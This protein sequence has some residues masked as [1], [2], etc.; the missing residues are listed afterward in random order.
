MYEKMYNDNIKKINDM[1][2]EFNEILND[3]EIDDFKAAISSYN[4]EINSKTDVFQLGIILLEDL[5]IVRSNQIPHISLIEKL[6]VYIL[7]NMLN[8]YS[9]ERKTISEAYN[10]FVNICINYDVNDKALIYSVK[11]SNYIPTADYPLPPGYFNKYS[12]N[13]NTVVDNTTP[14]NRTNTDYTGMPVINE[15]IIKKLKHPQESPIIEQRKLKRTKTMG[16]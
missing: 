7:E 12:T 2:V 8:I 14:L 1:V 16:I 5:L 3:A 10:D 11:S 9:V 6:I 4:E 13:T 15:D